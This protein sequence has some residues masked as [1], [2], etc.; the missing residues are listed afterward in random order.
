MTY[1]KERLKKYGID[2]E[3]NTFHNAIAENGVNRADFKWFTETKNGDISINYLSPDG[4]VEWFNHGNS[5][6]RRFV[7]IRKANP[8][9]GPKY[10]QEKGTE[11]IPFSTPSIIDA[12]KN[13]KIAIAINIGP[14]GPNTFLKHSPTRAEPATSVSI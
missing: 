1:F 7:R 2:E 5:Q 3:T 13:N 8:G 10:I 6:T 4:C 11:T 14:A 12:Y 9:D